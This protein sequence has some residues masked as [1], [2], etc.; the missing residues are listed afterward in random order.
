M[1]IFKV[2]QIKLFHKIKTNHSFKQLLNLNITNIIF[3]ILKQLSKL[4]LI[5]KVKFFL[6]KRI[7]FCATVISNDKIEF[8]LNFPNPNN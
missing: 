5:L 2:P 4:N 8:N 7:F 6:K 1:S 3:Q